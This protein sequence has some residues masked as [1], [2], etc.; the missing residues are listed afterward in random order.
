MRKENDYFVEG[1]LKELETKENVLAKAYQAQVLSAKVGFDFNSIDNVFDK[2]KEEFSEIEEAFNQR[3]KDREHFIEEIG[4]GFFA[5]INLARFV[6]VTPNELV[7]ATTKKYLGRMAYIEDKL[8]KEG[9]NW[10]DK[11]LQ[12][13]DEMWDRAKKRKL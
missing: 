9:E 13:L 1:L 2:V 7:Y 3:D 10:Q 12:E 11:N 5:L 6:G 4:D 8:K